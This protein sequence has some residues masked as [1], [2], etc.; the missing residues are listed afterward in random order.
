MVSKRINAILL[1]TIVACAPV[2]AAENQPTEIASEQQDTAKTCDS[3][4]VWYKKRSTHIVAT[5]AATAIGLYALAVRKN[6]I[7]G[8]IALFTAIFCANK[9][10]QEVKNPNEEKD[11]PGQQDQNQDNYQDKQIVPAPEKTEDSNNTEKHT[12]DL[13]VSENQTTVG[14]EIA[15][16]DPVVTKTEDKSPIVDV[17]GKNILPTHEAPLHIQA[18]QRAFDT[19]RTL[20]EWIIEGLV[21]DSLDN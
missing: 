9:K 16:V 20:K 19:L 11:V 4:V 21:K 8:P 15:P 17:V 13:V 2:Y 10:A 5:V 7:A 6:K 12:P 14:Q 1:T 18:Q 3:S